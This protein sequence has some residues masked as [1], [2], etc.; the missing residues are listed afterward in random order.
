MFCVKLGLMKQGPLVNLQFAL[1]LIQVKKIAQHFWFYPGLG[2]VLD[3]PFFSS[4]ACGAEGQP[5]ISIGSPSPWLG[6]RND[7]KSIGEKNS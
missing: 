6:F 5:L 4:M 3:A 2:E 1:I 7:K